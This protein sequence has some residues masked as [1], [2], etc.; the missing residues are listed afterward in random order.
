MIYIAR[1]IIARQVINESS[2]IS[3]HRRILALGSCHQIVIVDDVSVLYSRIDKVEEI[4][5]IQMRGRSLQLQKIKLHSQQPSKISTRTVRKKLQN[6]Q[7][8]RREI[9]LNMS[10]AI[11]ACIWHKILGTIDGDRELQFFI[12]RRVEKFEL[13]NICFTARCNYF[14]LRRS[15]YRMQAYVSAKEQWEIRNGEE[16]GGEH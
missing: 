14:R 5:L 15:L 4:C 3:K 10:I 16:K 7:R 8:T 9:A 11:L 2:N 13:T 1:K 6:V 12:A